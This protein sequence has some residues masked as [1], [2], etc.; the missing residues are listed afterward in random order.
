MSFLS[1]RSKVVMIKRIRPGSGD[2]NPSDIVVEYFA[3]G[4]NWVTDPGHWE[5]AK[6]NIA[7]ARKFIRENKLVNV[8]TVRAPYSYSMVKM[9]GIWYAVDPLFNRFREIEVEIGYGEGYYIEGFNSEPRKLVISYAASHYTEITVQN[10]K[11]LE[12]SNLWGGEQFNTESFSIP[13][14]NEVLRF[15]KFNKDLLTDNIIVDTEVDNVQAS[16]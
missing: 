1:N 14:T 10:N 4:D 8:E 3:G 15:F 12:V 9:H 6:M 2:T 5:V 13:D 16:S 11:I 7:R